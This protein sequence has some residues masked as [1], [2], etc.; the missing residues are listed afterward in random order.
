MIKGESRETEGERK[1]RTWRKVLKDRELEK[2]EKL[3]QS[4]MKGKEKIDK[5]RFFQ[6]RKRSTEPQRQNPGEKRSKRLSL[7][8]VCLLQSFSLPLFPSLCISFFLP[9]SLSPSLSPMG[10]S[11]FVPPSPWL[12]P[13][14]LPFSLLLSCTLVPPNK[15][16]SLPFEAFLSFFFIAL[17]LHSLLF[18][19]FSLL[20]SL[21]AYFTSITYF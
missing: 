7:L 15:L 6:S 1:L 17:C 9:V 10:Y 14:P 11:L 4:R 21:L 16:P 8:S 18:T 12:L 2:T 19:I 5:R 3:S 20:K 13:I